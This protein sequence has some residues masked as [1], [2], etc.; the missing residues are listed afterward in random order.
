MSILYYKD[1]LYSIKEFLDNIDIIELIVT[2][3][4]IKK[5][6]GETN[7]F[8][9]ITIHKQSNICDMIRYYI[10]HKKSIIKTTIINTKDPSS[11]WPFSS[12]NMIFID[13]DVNYTYTDKNYKKAK[14]LIIN[15]YKYPRFWH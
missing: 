14:T 7:L 11:L 2:S 8:I 15:N 6:L 12:K 10:K 4:N 13:C 9:T 1:I 5:I 3:K